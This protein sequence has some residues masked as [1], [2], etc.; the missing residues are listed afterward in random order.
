MR[1][2]VDQ[3][4]HAGEDSSVSALGRRSQSALQSGEAFPEH[5]GAK[6]TPGGRIRRRIRRWNHHNVNVHELYNR[7][8]T[9]RSFGPGTQSAAKKKKRKRKKSILPSDAAQQ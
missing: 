8:Q 7:R 9:S 5:L 6:N 2:C 1:L 3:Q 4:Q